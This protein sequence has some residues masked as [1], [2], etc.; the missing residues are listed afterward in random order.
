MQGVSVVKEMDCKKQLE[1]RQ[2][3]V[4]GLLYFCGSYKLIL[5]QP[6]VQVS[7]RGC[8]IQ[9]HSWRCTG[10]LQS[11]GWR[12]ILF[13]LAIRCCNVIDMNHLPDA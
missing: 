7:T 2:A 4:Y 3:A 12:L 8:N 10:G 11:A 9:C 6:N 1:I 13:M 5:E